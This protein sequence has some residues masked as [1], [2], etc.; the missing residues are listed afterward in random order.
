MNRGK[1]VLFGSVSDNP[2]G[3]GRRSL[4]A[5]LEKVVLD[6]PDSHRF[7]ETMWEDLFDQWM[8]ASTQLD[9]V[10]RQHITHFSEDGF[11]VT[12]ERTYP[13]RNVAAPRST[14]RQIPVQARE[15]L[16]PV[17]ALARNMDGSAR[18]PRRIFAPIPRDMGWQEEVWQQANM[19]GTGSAIHQHLIDLAR[20]EMRNAAGS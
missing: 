9:E 15:S 11:E 8:T 10:A 16:G 7:R 6:G 20:E 19:A 18:N 14:L 4:R 1:M 12:Y 5:V 13:I 2:N 3:R 17:E